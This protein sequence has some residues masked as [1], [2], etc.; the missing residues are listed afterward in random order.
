MII[1]GIDGRVKPLIVAKDPLMLQG[2]GDWG[3][4]RSRRRAARVRHHEDR[5]D[6]GTREL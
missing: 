3:L 1:K 5:S 2:G 6:E 4:G